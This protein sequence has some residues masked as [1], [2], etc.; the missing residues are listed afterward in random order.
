MTGTQ[1]RHWLRDVLGLVKFSHSIFALPFALAGAW[2]AAAGVPR[3]ATLG[4]IV[5]C[6]VA[7]RTAAMGFNRLV[8]RDLDAANPRT[9]ARELPR[10]ALSPTAVVLLVLGSAA[11]FVAGAF[12][13]GT[14]PGSLA[15]PVLAVLL[16]Y[17]YV[18]RFS[19]LAH[20]VLGLALALAP[21]GAWV[22]VRGAIEGP[23]APVLCLALAVW[24]W[25]AGFD[26]IYACQDV[27]FDRGASLFSIPARWGVPTALR[28]SAI[29]HLLTVICLFALWQFAAM[30]PIFLCGVI[31]VAI[32]LAYEHRLVRPDD[33]TRV[34]AA[35]FNVNA[36]ISIGLFVVGLAD[37]WLG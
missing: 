18:K 21:L 11:V 9:A 23:L 20:F 17:S 3:L 24:T 33:L 29:S 5:L 22:A 34:N 13:L 25:V 6:A 4:W 1:G 8:D 27:E 15:P 37:V 19:A 35:F 26:L 14:V 36:V 12:Q 32:L 2:L 10:G 16:G 28:I 30:G 31:A 7:A